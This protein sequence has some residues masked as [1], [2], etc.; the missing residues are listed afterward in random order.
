MVMNGTPFST[1]SDMSP[2]CARVPNQLDLRV[3]GRGLYF[4]VLN[5]KPFITA[6][7]M[8]PGCV[9]VPN[10]PDLPIR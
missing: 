3:L 5:G 1:A 9:R 2:G 6:S 7:D 8:G 4:L 10:H